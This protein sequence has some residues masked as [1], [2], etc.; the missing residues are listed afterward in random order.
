MGT[1]GTMGRVVQ[2]RAFSSGS[3]PHLG[4]TIRKHT[5]GKIMSI[6]LIAFIVAVCGMC[7]KSD[8]IVG[9]STMVML[10]SAW[11][12]LIDSGIVS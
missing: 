3:A 10:F 8:V 4:R 1:T 5:G 6:M 11:N 2:S 7:T 12:L 9:T